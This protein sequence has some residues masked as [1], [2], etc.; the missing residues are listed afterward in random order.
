MFVKGARVVITEF[1]FK[2]EGYDLR[3]TRGVG[4]RHELAEYKYTSDV[5]ALWVDAN[6]SEHGYGSRPISGPRQN[7]FGAVVNAAAYERFYAFVASGTR[8]FMQYFIV[9]NVLKRVSPVGSV[10]L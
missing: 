3:G 8:A 1:T 2:Q 5:I 6:G 4:V 7:S 9:I 10:G